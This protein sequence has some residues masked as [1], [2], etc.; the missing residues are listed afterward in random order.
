VRRRSLHLFAARWI[1]GDGL[2]RDLC[3]TGRRI[4]AR[5]AHRIG[6]VSAVVREE[7]LMERAIQ[8]A[9]TVMEAPAVTL[10]FV[11]GFFSGNAGKGFEESFQIE[12][13]QA[14][15]EIILKHQ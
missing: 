4:D 7:L 11:K 5:E 9:Q 13:D 1:I 15:R 6:M 14:F 8:L 2:A 12:H 3:L 10:Q